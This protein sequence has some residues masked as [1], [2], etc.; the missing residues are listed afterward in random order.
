MSV[1]AE[2]EALIE[3]PDTSNWLK[4]ALGSAL[5]RDCNDAVSDAEFLYRILERHA[6]ATLEAARATL[7]LRPELDQWSADL[8]LSIQGVR[9]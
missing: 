4:S 1:A 7:N 3:S 6:E 8:G 2:I 9:R 5:V